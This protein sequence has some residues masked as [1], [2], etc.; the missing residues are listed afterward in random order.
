[1]PTWVK[2]LT[3][4]TTIPTWI[5]VVVVELVHGDTPSPALMAIPAG[6]IIATSGTDFVIN[7][8]RR[9]ANNEGD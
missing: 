8:K 2:V 5:A 3:V 1:M 4:L 7:V 6:V 9:K